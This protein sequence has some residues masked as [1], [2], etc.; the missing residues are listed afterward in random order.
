MA[1]LFRNLAGIH[2]IVSI[3]LAI[4][5]LLNLIKI[6]NHTG[7]LTM[8]LVFRFAGVFICPLGAVLGFF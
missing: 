5:W 7:D 6:I 8:M 1:V 2:L 3:I 4:G